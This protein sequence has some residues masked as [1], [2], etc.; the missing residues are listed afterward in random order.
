M[1]GRDLS[2]FSRP[3][4]EV[5]AV[6]IKEITMSNQAEFHQHHT[7]FFMRKTS[8]LFLALAI[9]TLLG[10]VFFSV[11]SA[12]K[13]SGG[14]QTGSLPSNE[15]TSTVSTVNLGKPSASSL[16]FSERIGTPKS[17]SLLLP[18]APPSPDTVETFDVNCTTPKTAFLMG[19]TVC[20]KISGG[21]PLSLYPRKIAWVDNFNNIQKKVDITSDPQTDSFTLPVAGPTPLVDYRGEW[22]VNS[23]SAA[24]SSVRA[25]GF[26]SVSNPV[27]PAADLSIYNSNNTDGSITAG[28]NIEYVLWISNKG[29]DAASNVQV[30]D[31]TPANTTFLSGQQDSGPTFNCTFPA[32]NS[33]GGTTTCTL[34]S[35]ASGANARITLVY[36]VT[37]G[38]AANTT[39]AD[40][41][42]IASGTA[43]P[44]DDS[45]T[46][47]P[48]DPNAD[49]SNNTA[50]S[51]TTVVSG[52]AG[53]TCTLQCPD[54]ITA[55]ADTTENGQRGAH[56]TY[57]APVASGSCGAVT[58]TPASGTFFPVG[59][60]VVNATSATGD[61]SCSFTVTVQEAGAPTI[62]CPP[63]KTASANSNCQATVDPG[64]PTTTGDNVTVTSSRS[65]GN[66]LT[67]PCPEEQ[68]TITWTP[69][70][71]AGSASC[72]QMITVADD[73]APSV[74]CPADVTRN[75]D[76]GQCSATVDPGTATATD[77]CGVASINGTRS[78]GQP[79]D[80]PYPVGTTTITWTATDRSDNTA[81]C[82]QT[83]TVN[84]SE[85]PTV[86][87]PAPTS[88]SADAN[89]Q[90]AVPDATSGATAS[91]NCG[92]VTLTQSPA[93]GSM[94]GQGTTTITV[95][96]TDGAGNT[97]TCTTTFTVND[98]TPPTVSCPAPTS[99]SAD[100]NCQAPVP[101]VASAATASDNCSAP[102]SITK[103]QSP[104]AGTM[105]G[106]GPHTITVTATDAA[107]NSST[108][109]STFTVNDTT[110]PTISCPAPSSASADA[111]CQAPVPDVRSGA[112]T[113]DNCGSATVTQSPA[114]GTMVGQGPQTIT[115][116]ATAGSGNS[117]SCTTT[118][119]VNDTTPPAITCPA[120]IATST[121]PGTCAAH[122]IPGAAT[123]TDNCGA[124]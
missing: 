115:V 3:G 103:T 39:I 31:A 36:N 9:I 79:L 11:S 59:T 116:T 90:A 24:R 87:C 67:D 19:E 85:K 107:G 91:D 109:T 5:F 113:S 28:S 111:N 94:V 74:T 46:P 17:F 53:A 54:N 65:D 20:A 52:A 55:S 23:I 86:S 25:S 40:T 69:T 16:R 117:S 112:T 61:G 12:H 98:N 114:P 64:Q 104:A 41:A 105:V 8:R 49:P 89:C 76:A 106:Y 50:T 82:T 97:S 43:D 83:V 71:S 84:D 78:D 10:T 77:N 1:R 72:Q 44:H 34:A 63:G 81:S 15:R 123:A 122:V 96:A 80:A 101:D 95:T 32:A 75:N 120:N 38:T 33:T 22:R 37:S 99:A 14:R 110:P 2:L 121:E 60:T 119:T 66:P 68:T 47:P 93:A 42:H 51:R 48:S 57:D 30:T 118:F 7:S 21:P 70:N 13:K 4:S 73:T 92:T 62:T 58:S 108:C 45:N 102:G 27:L 100:A 35:L 18:Q 56:V 124:A 29:P 6:P 88:A 26:F